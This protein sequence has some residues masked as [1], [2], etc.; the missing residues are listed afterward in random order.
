MKTRISNLYRT[1][2]E[3]NNIEFEPLAGELIIY[4][5]DDKYEYARLK[6]GDGKTSLSKLPFFIDT[7]IDAVIAEY[8]QAKCSD[9]GHIRQYFVE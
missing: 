6:V 4:A 1:E 7:N 9:A 8:D 2:A 5:P 3:W